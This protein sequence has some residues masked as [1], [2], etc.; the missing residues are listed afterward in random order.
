M[1]FKDAAETLNLQGDG[2]YSNGRE[3]RRALL[4]GMSSP[5]TRQTRCHSSISVLFRNIESRLQDTLDSG[6]QVELC[7]RLLSSIRSIS[8]VKHFSLQD[9]DSTDIVQDFADKAQS[10][11]E[12]HTWCKDTL[13]L[14]ENY[15]RLKHHQRLSFVL[16]LISRF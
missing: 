7:L 15:P 1:L 12:Y 4:R 2:E 8:Q 16:D 11:T 10:S 6:P 5:S 3:F 14:F 9:A 13:A